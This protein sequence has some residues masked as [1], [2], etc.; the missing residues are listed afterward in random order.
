MALTATFVQEAFQDM[1]LFIRQSNQYGSGMPELVAAESVKKRTQLGSGDLRIEVLGMALA[2]DRQNADLIES[3][4][5]QE[6]QIVDWYVT[7]YLAAA[8]QLQGNSAADILADFAERMWEDCTPPQAVLQNTVAVDGSPAADS[9]NEGDGTLGSI[10]LSQY[11]PAQRFTVECTDA[12][13]EGSEQWSVTGSVSGALDSATTGV[14]YTDGTTY[15]QFTITAGAA[16]FA[17]GDKFYFYTTCVERLF[18]TFFRDK[19]GK[20][21]ASVGTGSETIEEDWAR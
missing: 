17:V 16:A 2:Q 12:T 7:N 8:A 19:F 18:Q 9:D 14:A 20:V 6:V 13:T 5:G 1:G 11:I 21:M 3:M 10:S 4:A 15:L